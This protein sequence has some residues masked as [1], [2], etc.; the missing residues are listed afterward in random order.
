ME[1]LI[2]KLISLA[3]EF[4]Q[5]YTVSIYGL[6]LQTGYSNMADQ[7]SEKDLYNELA[8]HP[9]LAN[10]WLVYSQDKRCDTGW[11]FKS[12]DVNKYLV[13]CVNKNGN[14]ESEYDDK[15]KACAAFIKHELDVLCD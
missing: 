9:D 8:E 11:Y 14:A 15:L 10:D 7:I 13:G 1:N 4:S 2:L 3:R 5:K 12:K 6:L